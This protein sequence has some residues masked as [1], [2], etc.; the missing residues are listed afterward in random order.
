MCW[1][2]RLADQ[3]E[4]FAEVPRGILKDDLTKKSTMQFKLE[5]R[6]DS[7]VQS[8]AVFF[9]GFKEGSQNSS[10]MLEKGG[11]ECNCAMGLVRWVSKSIFFGWELSM[12]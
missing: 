1:R 7:W 9:V 5:D 2:C 4:Q 3:R 11:G 8:G 10:Q 6:G 12:S